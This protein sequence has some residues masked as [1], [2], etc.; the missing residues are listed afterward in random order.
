MRIAR[1]NLGIEPARL[2]TGRVQPYTQCPYINKSH[3]AGPI[4]LTPAG[5][6]GGTYHV[7][8]YIRIQLTP[9]H[10]SYTPGILKEEVELEGVFPGDG[11]ANVGIVIRTMRTEAMNRTIP[12][13]HLKQVRGFGNVQ[14]AAIV[15]VQP[16]QYLAGSSA[17]DNYILLLEVL[18]Q[19]DILRFQAG[20]GKGE[21]QQKQY[22]SYTGPAHEGPELKALKGP[23]IVFTHCNIKV[24]FTFCERKGTQNFLNRAHLQPEICPKMLRTNNTSAW[25]GVY[26]FLTRKICTLVRRQARLP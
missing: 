1:R 3:T 14:I 7:N 12:V 25:R 10:Q 8:P 2:K 21:N 5:H 6:I 19:Q 18:E 9:Y 4:V 22:V 11:A 26:F 23:G 15:A 16:V 20:G 24:K 17:K 13:T